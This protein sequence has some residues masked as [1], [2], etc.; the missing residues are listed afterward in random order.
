MSVDRQWCADTVE[1]DSRDPDHP[2]VVDCE[3]QLTDLGGRVHSHTIH[4][5]H[6]DLPNGVEVEVRWTRKGGGS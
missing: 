1:L 3:R 5:R 6:L 2:A 4:T